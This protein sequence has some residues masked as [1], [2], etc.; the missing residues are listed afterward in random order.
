MIILLGSFALISYVLN[1]FNFNQQHE[2]YA[3]IISHLLGNL[4]YVRQTVYIAEYLMLCYTFIFSSIKDF[5]DKSRR[6]KLKILLFI[7]PMFLFLDIIQ[8]FFFYKS[9]Y[10]IRHTILILNF[11]QI[12]TN[13]SDLKNPYYYIYWFYQCFW[14]IILNIIPLFILCILSIRADQEEL[15]EIKVEKELCITLEI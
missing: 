2:N 15:S 7:F 1:I 11:S 5:L 12:Y 4:I 6:T 14:N 10:W 8:K 3:K 13:F 9:H